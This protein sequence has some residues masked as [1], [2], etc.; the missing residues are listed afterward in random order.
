MHL[1]GNLAAL[2]VGLKVGMTVDEKAG[3]SVESLVAM[4][5]DCSVY[6]LHRQ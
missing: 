1:V 2:M 3:R 5:V 6:M 4:M